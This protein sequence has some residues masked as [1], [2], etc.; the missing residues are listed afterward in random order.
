MGNCVRRETGIEDR[1]IDETKQTET[2]DIINNIVSNKAFIK[3][4][5][6]KN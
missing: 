5:I 6:G 3:I 1:D 2:D 4:N